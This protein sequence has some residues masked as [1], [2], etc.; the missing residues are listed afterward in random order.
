[1]WLAPAPRGFY[2][3]RELPPRS[4][5]DAREGVGVGDKE[6]ACGADGGGDGWL[7]EWNDIG[8]GGGVS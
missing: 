5:R 6:R 3:R 7:D 8:G 1:M 2:T 4:S